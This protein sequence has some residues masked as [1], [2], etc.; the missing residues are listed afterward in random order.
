M[1][2]KLHFLYSHLDFFPANLGQIS[3]EQGER[4]HQY[5]RTMV[6]RYR[7][8]SNESM[9]TDYYWMLDKDVPGIRHS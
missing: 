1:S 4:F 2:L 5:I 8:L 7:N 9:M 6:T 3:D